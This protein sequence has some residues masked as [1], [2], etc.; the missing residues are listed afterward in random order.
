MES[1]IINKTYNQIISF[2]FK[3]NNNIDLI[4]ISKSIILSEI[5]NIL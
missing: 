1:D 5:K 2:P 3:T 4:E